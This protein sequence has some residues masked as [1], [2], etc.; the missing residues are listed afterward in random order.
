MRTGSCPRPCVIRYL[1]FRVLVAQPLVQLLLPDTFL[2]QPP[3]K[4]VPR[5]K[6]VKNSV[7]TRDVSLPPSR[8]S[9]LLFQTH[10]HQ[11][12]V[13]R[14]SQLDEVWFDAVHAFVNLPVLGCL[15]L[16]V[17]LQASPAVDN[18]ADSRL[19]LIIIVHNPAGE[20]ERESHL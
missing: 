13:S 2:S 15:L 9:R 3:G 8:A 14:L 6:H 11:V 7:F 5:G 1:L 17:F 10:L 20:R 4:A 12:L 19:Q 18:L 16:Q